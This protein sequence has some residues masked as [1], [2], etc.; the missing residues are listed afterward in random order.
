M[1]IKDANGENVAVPAV[2]DKSGNDT[3]TEL[4]AKD[5]MIIENM[6]N[7]SNFAKT[8]REITRILVAVAVLAVIGAVFLL[9]A[10]ARRRGN[11]G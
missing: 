6:K 8:G 2:T 9:A 7:A 4:A 1:Y 3:T 11:N 5:A 10:H